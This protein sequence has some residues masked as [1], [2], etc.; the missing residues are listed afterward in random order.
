MAGN[1]ARG[2]TEDEVNGSVSVHF[3]ALF[4]V[5]ERLETFTASVL[6]WP[7]DSGSCTPQKVSI[8]LH[9]SSRWVL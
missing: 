3:G 7:F 9:C 2:N 5:E 4:T 8:Y 1:H 6:S